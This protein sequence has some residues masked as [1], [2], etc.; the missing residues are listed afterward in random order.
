MESER[1]ILKQPIA[2][3]IARGGSKR[4]PR[5]NV[6]P[7]CG[8][9]LVEWSI[10]QACCSRHIGPENTYLSTD[11]D[12]IAFI[13]KRN[14]IH[15]LRRPERP[16][17]DTRT[18]SQ[19]FVWAIK[20]IEKERDFDTLIGA[21]PTSPVRHPWDMDANIERYYELK[22]KYPEMWCLMNSVPNEETIVYKYLDNARLI[23]W[24]LSKGR[25]FGGQGIN[26]NCHDKD[27]YKRVQSQS[28]FD[29]NITESNIWMDPASE[30]QVQFYR[31]TEWYQQY[32]IDNRD[33][34]ELCEIMMERYILKGRGDR[35]YYDY[36]DGKE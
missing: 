36:R 4:L 30:G 32:D 20:Q 33:I 2:V 31:P 6:L 21:L 11:D 26:A 16:D 3:I 18:G 15:V 34:F 28:H 14:K 7:F 17:A 9:P 12:E 13:G 25:W 22:S 10:I 29:R 27:G 24:L 35:V 5:K 23:W 8:L 19:E 1:L